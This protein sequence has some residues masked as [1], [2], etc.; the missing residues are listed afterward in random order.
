MQTISLVAG[1][2]LRSVTGTHVI[3]SNGFATVAEVDTDV[4]VNDEVYDAV[5]ANIQED[6]TIRGVDPDTG[7]PLPPPDPE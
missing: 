3:D 1:E 4:E 7:L 5:W 2:Y 6:R